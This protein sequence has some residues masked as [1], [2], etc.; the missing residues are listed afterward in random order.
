[1]RK[2][3]IHLGWHKTGSTSIQYFITINHLAF[4]SFFNIYVP[5]AGRLPA[6]IINHHNLAWDLTK[7]KRYNPRHGNL[8]NLVD[9]IK[10]CNKDVLLTAEDFEFLVNMPEQLR[11]FEE[12]I[13][14][15]NYKIYYIYYYRNNSTHALSIYNLLKYFSDK[16]FFKLE[17][18]FKFFIKVYKNGFYIPPETNWTFYFDKKKFNNKFNKITNGSVIEIDFNKNKENLFDS[19]LKNIKITESKKFQF[20]TNK[21]NVTKYEKNLNYY[22]MLFLSKII[23][24]KYK[25]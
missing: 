17:S 2:I 5:R 8:Q 21:K 16:G 25:V 14:Q 20:P 11:L 1:M 6:E 18:I 24:I 15:I 19:F 13:N 7:D 4:K 10:N 9:E 12:K 3:F 23:H 22:L